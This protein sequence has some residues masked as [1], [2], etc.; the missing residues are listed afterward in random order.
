MGEKLYG[1][2]PRHLFNRIIYAM[3]IV[4]GLVFFF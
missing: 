3:L 1:M 4:T 2:I